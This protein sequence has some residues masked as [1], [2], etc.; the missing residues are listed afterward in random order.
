MYQKKH[1]HWTYSTQQL[2]PDIVIKQVYVFV[3][4]RKGYCNLWLIIY[5]PWFRWIFGGLK[6]GNYHYSNSKN[7]KKKRKPLIS[8]VL[9][10]RIVLYCFSILNVQALTGVLTPRSSALFCPSQ[11]ALNKQCRLFLQD[12]DICNSE[13]WVLTIITMFGRWYWVLCY[14]KTF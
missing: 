9:S 14:S 7:N 12:A 11:Y 8:T 13:P 6:R 5:F 3:V 1:W 4:R 2:S 10:S